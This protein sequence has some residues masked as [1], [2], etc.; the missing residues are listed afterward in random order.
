[1]LSPFIIHLHDQLEP[2]CI[3]FSKLQ[4]NNW[5]LLGQICII[6]VKS[7]CP[8]V[9]ST[10]VV[11]LTLQFHGNRDQHP[12]I[13][14]EIHRCDVILSSEE[15]LQ[16]PSHCLHS[17]QTSN[18]DLKFEQWCVGIYVIAALSHLVWSNHPFTEIHYSCRISMSSSSDLSSIYT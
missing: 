6:K 4:H 1:M 2:R 11:F 5:F 9:S 18:L 7:L 15:E 14:I 10:L 12:W 16:L 3:D 17:D 8:T 13:S